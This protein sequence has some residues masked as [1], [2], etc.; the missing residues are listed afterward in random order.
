MDKAE[1]LKQQFIFDW[2]P[3]D[4]Q[5]SIHNQNFQF[6]LNKLLD[7]VSREVAVGF[8]KAYYRYSELNIGAADI[9]LT[10]HITAYYDEWKSK[11]KQL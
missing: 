5:E 1:E 3:S 4:Q 6:E 9:Y 2:Q 8:A 10:E 7:E 11:Q